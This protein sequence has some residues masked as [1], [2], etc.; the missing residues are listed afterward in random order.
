MKGNNELIL[1][2]ATMIVAV[3]EYINKRITVETP[4]VTGIRFRNDVF[5]VG[6]E[7]QANGPDERKP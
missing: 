3:Q 4:L 2:E 5:T 6:L 1:N 7:G